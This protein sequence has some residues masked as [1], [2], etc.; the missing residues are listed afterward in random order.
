MP[1]VVRVQKRFRELDGWVSKA[2]N[3]SGKAKA[4]PP[5]KEV[6]KEVPIS[7]KKRPG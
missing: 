7:T 2:L 4:A 1:G 3:T 5:K 6:V